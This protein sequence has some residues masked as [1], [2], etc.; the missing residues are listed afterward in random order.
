[1][2]YLTGYAAVAV[3]MAGLDF[4]W[5]RTMGAPLY[6]RTIGS[7]MA[8]DPDMKAAVAFYVLYVAGIVWFAVRPG[9]TAGDWRAAA[10]NGALFG[11]FAYGTYDLTN[12]AT[13]KVWSLKLTLADMTWGTV[14]TA[15]SGGAGAGLMLLLWPHRSGA[16]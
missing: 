5:L 8:K 4:L 14:L 15:V 2:R 11:L 1:M 6:E 10:L 9:V 16:A 13:L 3:V 7:L 12:M